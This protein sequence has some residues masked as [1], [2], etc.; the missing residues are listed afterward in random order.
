MPLNPPKEDWLGHKVYVNIYLNKQYIYTY[1]IS[2]KPLMAKF[3]YYLF[4]KYTHIYPYYT[5]VDLY[6]AVYLHKKYN[7]SVNLKCY[8]YFFLIVKK[9]YLALLKNVFKENNLP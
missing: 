5:A 3:I 2:S 6:A 1:I 7:S 8:I 4:I 9:H